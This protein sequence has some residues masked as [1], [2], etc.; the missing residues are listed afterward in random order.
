MTTAFFEQIGQQYN[1]VRFLLATAETQG[2]K[3]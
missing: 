1:L 3:Y 2:K